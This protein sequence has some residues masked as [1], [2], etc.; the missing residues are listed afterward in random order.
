VTRNEHTNT[1]AGHRRV[2]AGVAIGAALLLGACGT[3]NALS[4]STT[5]ETGRA[6]VVRDPD[7]ASWTG[8]QASDGLTGSTHASVI[9]DSDN[10][11]WTGA[12][13]T[14][15]AVSDPAAD[16]RLRGPR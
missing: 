4:R 6:A 1:G 3:A 14:R 5:S 7:N 13:A 9:R 2:M 10:P 16:P 12:D 11:Y 15:I 8:F